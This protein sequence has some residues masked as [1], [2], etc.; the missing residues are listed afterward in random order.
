MHRWVGR[1]V[2]E[3]RKGGLNE[4]LYVVGGWVGGWVGGK[5]DVPEERPL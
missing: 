4:L 2:E 3:G 1:W 5:E